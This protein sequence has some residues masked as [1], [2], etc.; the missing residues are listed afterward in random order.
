MVLWTKLIVWVRNGELA[1]V[2]TIYSFL[3]E[4]KASTITTIS[5]Q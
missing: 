2:K 1:F 3:N 5:V 4:S